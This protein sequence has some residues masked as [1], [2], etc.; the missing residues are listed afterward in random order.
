[1]KKRWIY[2]THGKVAVP[3][4]V[5]MQEANVIARREFGPGTRDRATKIKDAITE[6]SRKRRNG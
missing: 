4:N 6:L 5:T 3:N 1:M 2:L